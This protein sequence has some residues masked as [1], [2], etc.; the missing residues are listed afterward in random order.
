MS[1]FENPLLYHLPLTGMV[2]FPTWLL[3]VPPMSPGP[4]PVST[5]WLVLTKHY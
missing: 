1:S 5:P 2:D 3:P 4:R